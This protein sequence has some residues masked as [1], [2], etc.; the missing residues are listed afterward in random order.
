MG[1]VHLAR[2]IRHF[3]EIYNTFSTSLSEDC[4]R[5]FRNLRLGCIKDSPVFEN[6]QNLNIFDN[7]IWWI[8][9]WSLLT[10]FD[11]P[12]LSRELMYRV[13]YRLEMDSISLMISMTLTLYFGFFDKIHSSENHYRLQINAL[14]SNATTETSKNDSTTGNHVISVI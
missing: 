4:S 13:S 3:G 5:G 14:T 8:L 9:R 7:G 11:L 10:T 2:I 12:H 1:F 6:A